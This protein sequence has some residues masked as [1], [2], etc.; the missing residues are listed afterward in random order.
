MGT[1]LRKIIN[2]TTEDFVTKRELVRQQ[3]VMSGRNR[4]TETVVEN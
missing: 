3:K 2:E 1:A 4:L